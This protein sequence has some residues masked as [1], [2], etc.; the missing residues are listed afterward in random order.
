MGIVAAAGDYQKRL[1]GLKD[2]A[3]AKFKAAAKNII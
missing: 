1:I 2:E 3:I